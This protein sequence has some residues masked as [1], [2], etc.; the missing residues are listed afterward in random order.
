MKYV[1]LASPTGREL[2][3]LFDESITHRDVV[4]AK[5]HGYRVVSAGF[6]VRG[7]TGWTTHGES[8]SVGVGSRPEED[9]GVILNMLSQHS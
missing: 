6:L 7:K 5:V 9:L 4:P 3:I 1:I 8:Q 2:P